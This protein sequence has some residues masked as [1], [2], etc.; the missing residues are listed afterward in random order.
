VAVLCL[1]ATAACASGGVA[2]RASSSGHA[3]TTAS[4]DVSLVAQATVPVIDVYG[5]PSDTKPAQALHSPDPS[6]APLVFLVRRVAAPWVFAYLP[7]RPNGSSG[8]FHLAD[9]RLFE[10]DFRIVVQLR[11]HEIKVYEGSK[12]VDAEPIAVG[13]KET[14]TPGGIYY[15]KELLKPTNPAGPYG[16]YAYGLSG[17]SNVLMT[18]GSGDG[19]I[20]IHGTNDPSA[21]G[22][23]VSHGCIRMSNDGITKLA[24]LLPLGV[25]VDIET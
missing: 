21:L 24:H 6:G 13:K 1:A 11:A 18:F 10:H 3:S 17:F 16:P 12:V 23:D 2:T 4:N 14:P 19:V 5:S 8:W 20:G 25:P 15:T 22:H 9:V 7:V